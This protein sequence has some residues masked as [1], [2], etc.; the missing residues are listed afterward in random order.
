MGTQLNYEFGL[1]WTLYYKLIDENNSFGSH[2]IKQGFLLSTA[3]DF[4]LNGC[5]FKIMSFYSKD[6]SFDASMKRI[7]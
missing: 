1:K 5:L 6:K 3:D 4:Q 7:R 2:I